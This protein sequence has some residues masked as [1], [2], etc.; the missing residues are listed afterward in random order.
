MLNYTYTI[1]ASESKEC[2]RRKFVTDEIFVYYIVRKNKLI[3]IILLAKGRP[4][5]LILKIIAGLSVL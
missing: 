4:S 1:Y 2:S 5:N 3:L